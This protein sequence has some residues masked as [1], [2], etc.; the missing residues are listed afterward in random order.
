MP[1]DLMD[2]DPSDFDITIQ[3]YN[4][5]SKKAKLVNEKAELL[6]SLDKAPYKDMIKIQEEIFKLEEQIKKMDQDR[7]DAVS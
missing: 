2:T 5:A 6:R 1:D 7:N 4:F 3:N